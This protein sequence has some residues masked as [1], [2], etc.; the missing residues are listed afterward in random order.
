MNH[1]SRLWHKLTALPPVPAMG[2]YRPTDSAEAAF[3][4]FSERI[5]AVLARFDALVE[6][7]VAAFNRQV[8]EA[9]VAAVGV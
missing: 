8:A 6:A 3:A 2:D 9:Q 5:D 7:D 1:G 4:D